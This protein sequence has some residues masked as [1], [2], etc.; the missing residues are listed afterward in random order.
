MV[1]VTTELVVIRL[2]ATASVFEVGAKK[3]F[4]AFLFIVW[5]PVVVKEVLSMKRFL[6]SVPE[7]PSEIVA[8][9]VGNRVVDHTITP[10]LFD[11]VR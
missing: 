7:A 9:A 8:A 4:P 10:T 5:F 2:F 11:N 6:N 1:T 3:T